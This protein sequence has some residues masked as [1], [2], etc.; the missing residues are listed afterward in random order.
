VVTKKPKLPIGDLIDKLYA[1]DKIISEI[2]AELK[3]AKDVRMRVETRLLKR[4]SIGKLKGARGK[5]AI[6]FIK[7]TRHVSMKERPKLLKYI[8]KH[9]AFD[10]FTNAIA[11]KAYFDRL[12]DGEN[13]PGVAV[14]TNTRVNVQR[15]K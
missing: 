6:A 15:A 5:H 8:L 2:N 11:S 9:K 13:I 14:Y 1:H 7:K 12:D 3:A 4:L 10:L